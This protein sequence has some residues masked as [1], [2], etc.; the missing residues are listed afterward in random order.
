[1]ILGISLFSLEIDTSSNIAESKISTTVNP[2]VGGSNPSRG[3]SEIWHLRHFSIIY[4][5][6]VAQ[7]I[8]PSLAILNPNVGPRLHS[9]FLGLCLRQD[10]Q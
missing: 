9:E 1:M 10:G 7:A 2:L 8:E 4:C 3:A 5:A 6:T